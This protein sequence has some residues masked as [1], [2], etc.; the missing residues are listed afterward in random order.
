MWEKKYGW[1]K[2]KTYTTH[3]SRGYSQAGSLG[4]AW[5]AADTAPV[6]ALSI[7]LL[8]C[9]GTIL[10]RRVEL[11]ALTV[12][13]FGRGV[14]GTSP[15]P[16]VAVLLPL[17]FTV[18]DDRVV[19]LASAELGLPRTT[20]AGLDVPTGACELGGREREAERAV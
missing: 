15:L 7:A 16:F 19:E 14:A 12:E 10:G 3:N 11:G 6:V 2:R 18:R 1:E 5:L 9:L 13:A 8:F 17:P 4:F 20:E